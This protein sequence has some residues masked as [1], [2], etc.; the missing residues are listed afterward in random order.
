MDKILL[1]TDGSENSLKAAEYVAGVL[2][3]LPNTSIVVL[4]VIPRDR[5]LGMFEMHISDSELEF[6]RAKS[7][8]RSKFIIEQTIKPLIKY[9]NNIETMIKVGV[10]GETIAEVAQEIAA[11]HVVMGTRGNTGLKGLFLGSVAQRVMQLVNI[12]LTL[13]KD[14]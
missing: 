9:S 13:I 4:T 8:E 2:K 3:K 14:N 12:P 7:E 1:T 10:P 6:L 5:D 11:T